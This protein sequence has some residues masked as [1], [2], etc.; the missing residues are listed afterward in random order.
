VVV[1]TI[2]VETPG[3]QLTAQA[4]EHKEPMDKTVTATEPEAVA[5]V[6]A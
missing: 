5:V 4:Q 1:L 2:V 6:V 3:I